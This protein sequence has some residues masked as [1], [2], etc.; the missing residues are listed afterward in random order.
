[1]GICPSKLIDRQV[2]TLSLL[3]KPN[4]PDQLPALPKEIWHKVIAFTDVETAVNASRCSR[5]ID[6]AVMKLSCNEQ[7]LLYSAVTPEQSA[8]WSIDPKSPSLLLDYIAKYDSS[9]H[10]RDRAVCHENISPETCHYVVTHDEYVHARRGAFENANARQET[11]LHAALND[12]N[13]ESRSCAVSKIT[14]R[15]ALTRIAEA[16]LNRR[17]PHWLVMEALREHNLMNGN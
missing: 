10:T 15:E 13:P 17:T 8:R 3:H 9:D 12:P 4:K 5:C 11:V 6:S 2:K 16:E 7:R 14:S 1:M